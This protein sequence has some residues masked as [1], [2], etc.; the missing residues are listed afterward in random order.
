MMRSERPINRKTR[1]IL[2]IG[3]RYPYSFYPARRPRSWLRFDFNLAVSSSP[4][5]NSIARPDGLT[6]SL[7]TRDRYR[8]SR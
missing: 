3:Q 4:S 8:E 5:D 1:R 7:G 2:P 6:P